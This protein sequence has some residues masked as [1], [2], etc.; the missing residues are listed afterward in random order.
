MVAMDMW[1]AYLR[2]VREH[3][4]ALSAFDKSRTGYP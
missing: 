1:P 2:S 4:Q 3:T